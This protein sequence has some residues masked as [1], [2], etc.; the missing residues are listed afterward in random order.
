MLLHFFGYEMPCGDATAARSR[1]G[2]CESRLR[3]VDLLRLLLRL[4]MCL[5]L[6]MLPLRSLLVVCS[7]VCHLGRLLRW[8]RDRARQI[9]GRH[10]GLRRQWDST[11]QIGARH[12][13]LR[14]RDSVR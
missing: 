5:P 6:R 4:M 3:L 12:R 14:Q 2:L 9:G 13:R 11:R 10:G 7:G 1:R 8:Q